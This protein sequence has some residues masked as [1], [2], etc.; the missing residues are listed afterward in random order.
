MGHGTAAPVGAA[1]AAPGRPVF[2]IIGD[3]CFTMQGME[4]LTAVEYDIPVVWI[5]ENNQ[6]HGITYHGSKLVGDGKPMECIRYR[7]GIDIAG[8]ARAMGLLAWVVDR[9]GEMIDVLGQAIAAGRPA[10]IEVRVDAL[11]APPLGERARAIA[12][13]RN[14]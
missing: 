5:V 12:G 3:A 2:S 10:L 11:I 8:I 6:M 4:L 13:F 9:P 14:Q 7:R 1:L